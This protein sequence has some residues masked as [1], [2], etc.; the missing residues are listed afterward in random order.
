MVMSA[1]RLDSFEFWRFSCMYSQ[2]T[3]HKK[4]YVFPI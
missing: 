4:S 2:K 3:D 1:D